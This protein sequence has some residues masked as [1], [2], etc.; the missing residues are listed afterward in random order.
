[1]ALKIVKLLGLDELIKVDNKRIF[2]KHND[3]TIILEDVK[4]LGLFIEVERLISDDK[5]DPDVIKEEIRD[6]IKTLNLKN[7]KELN[8]GKNQLMLMRKNKN[9]DVKVYREW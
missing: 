6:F 3:L 7:V 2:Y 4:E 5:I 1:M 8:V 9:I